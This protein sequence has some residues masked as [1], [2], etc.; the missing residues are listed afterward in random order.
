MLSLS[1]ATAP[2]PRQAQLQFIWNCWAL[3]RPDKGVSFHTTDDHR[4]V[5]CRRGSLYR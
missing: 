5:F 2:A 3:V 1:F 4:P